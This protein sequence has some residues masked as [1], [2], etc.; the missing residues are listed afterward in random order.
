VLHKISDM[1]GKINAMY[2]LSIR[3]EKMKYGTP[4]EKQNK[5]EIDHMIEQL[6]QMAGEIYN[7]KSL[8]S[9]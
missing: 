8:Y 7:D 9:K 4:K 3:L 6:Q 2:Q 5:F 1:C